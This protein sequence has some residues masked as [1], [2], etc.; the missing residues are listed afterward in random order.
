MAAWGQDSTMNVS[1]FFYPPNFETQVSGL[2]WQ[3]QSASTFCEGSYTSCWPEIMALRC[4]PTL[5]LTHSSA[6]QGPSGLNSLVLT[7]LAP[8]CSVHSVS[9]LVRASPAMRQIH[10]AHP[11][12]GVAARIL[13][14]RLQLSSIGGYSL[15]EMDQIEQLATEQLQ[16]CQKHPLPRPGPS[17]HVSKFVHWLG[18]D[19]CLRAS[20]SGVAR[21]LEGLFKAFTTT[22]AYMALA[23]VHRKRAEER[24]KEVGKLTYLDPTEAQRALELYVN[25]ILKGKTS[26]DLLSAIS[27]RRHGSLQVS[28]KL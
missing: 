27:M 11:G 6:L 24:E 17:E 15:N 20:V 4:S 26:V 25:Q 22:Q 2:S 1:I 14:C 28:I 23:L 3:A 8:V 5:A 9:L 13:E 7:K 10:V 16:S 19:A 18:F 12:R 21:H